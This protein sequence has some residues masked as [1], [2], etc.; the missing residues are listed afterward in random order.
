MNCPIA[1]KA[2]YN[3]KCRNQ[4]YKVGKT[5]T[6]DRMEIC[7]LGFHFCYNMADTLRYYRP[8]RDFVLLEIAVMG[9]VETDR[10]KSVTDKFKV[11]RVVP[12]EE[13]TE[14][15]IAGLA[16]FEYDERGN[17]TKE[18]FDPDSYWIY[19][20]DDRNNKISNTDECGDRWTFEY[21]EHN[22]LITETD[23]NGTGIKYAYDERGNVT[24]K[25]Y[26]DNAKLTF[27]YDE[28]NNLIAVTTPTGNRYTYEVANITEED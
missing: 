27:E 18:Y 2:T 7:R 13:Y 10:N 15:M 1:Y 3:F 20:Y 5:Y 14:E 11:L 23:F 25:V 4:E 21:D 17:I 6:A 26:S 22:K 8:K 24:S 16:A 12:K 19:E 28:H 9:S